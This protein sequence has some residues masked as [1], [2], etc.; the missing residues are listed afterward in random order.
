MNVGDKYLNI[1]VSAGK[2]LE[3]AELV[4]L[5]LSKG[6]DKIYIKAFPYEKTVDNSPVFVGDGVAVFENTKKAISNTENV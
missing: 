6:E 1:S 5:G 3:L 2:I 4:K